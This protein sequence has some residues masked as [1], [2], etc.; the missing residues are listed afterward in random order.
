MKR[1]IRLILTLS[2]IILFY[3]M[4]TVVKAESTTEWKLWPSQPDVKIYKEWEIKFSEAVDY[5][6]L[7]RENI[8]IVRERDNAKI[9]VNPIIFSED[10]HVVKLGLH[11]LFDFDETYYLYVKDVKSI[12]GSTLKEPIKMKFQ[13]EKVEFNI[14]KT[15]EQEGLKFDVSLG[16]TVDNLYA[17]VKVMNVSEDSIPYWGSDGCDRG[18]SASV[19]TKNNT[20]ETKVGSKWFNSLIAC[21]AAL[22]QKS[23]KPGET[24]EIFE[25]LYLPAQP[26]FENNYL[27][28]TFKKG[29]LED[30]PYPSQISVEIPIE[31]K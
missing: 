5:R 12:K 9:A 28:L 22:W 23:L 19:L 15:T 20:G 26:L 31:L 21:N 18:L 7:S 29:N 13:T 2:L 8:M 27:Q 24:V 3:A 6:N 14:N 25:V 17:K 11:E 10:Q 16:Q 1:P 30:R 4:P